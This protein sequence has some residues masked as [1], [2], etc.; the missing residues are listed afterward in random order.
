MERQTAEEGKTGT[1]PGKEPEVSAT[2][3]EK[4]AEDCDP[5]QGENGKDLE[6]LEALAL[7]I[8]QEA[9]GDGCCDECRLRVADVVL[10]RVADERFPDT[11]QEVV[12]QEGQYGMLSSTGLV[13]PERADNPLEADAL[14]RA[15]QTAREVLKG[16]HSELYGAGYIWQAEFEQGTDHVY[17]C[18]ICYGR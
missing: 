17:C 16:R 3:A 6:G 13:W 14:E 2:A 18:G 12:L 4:S 9:G 7:V 15:W 11:I 5:T 10:N 1:K 8:Y